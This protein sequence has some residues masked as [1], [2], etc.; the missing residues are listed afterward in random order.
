MNFSN[1]L[2]SNRTD[3]TK[4]GLSVDD[5]GAIEACLLVKKKIDTVFLSP[6]EI[7]ILK[8]KDKLPKDYIEYIPTKSNKVAQLGSM[9][10]IKQI[11][12]DGSVIEEAV[13]IFSRI[14]FL[15]TD[16][17]YEVGNEDGVS[18]FYPIVPY[19]SPLGSAI[20]GHMVGGDYLVWHSND[21]QSKVSILEI[22]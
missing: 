20:L 19:T 11:L 12:R 9:V 2:L 7:R 8:D 3:E 21:T 22:E 14:T 1:E 6:E 18:R 10:R 16:G 15:A 4:D 17:E 5:L 13:M